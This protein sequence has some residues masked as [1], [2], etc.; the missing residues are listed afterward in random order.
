MFGVS[1]FYYICLINITINRFYKPKFLPNSSNMKKLF[2]FTLMVVTF[3]NFQAQN[4]NIGFKAGA[5]YA[6]LTNYE[7]GYSSRFAYHFGLVAELTLTDNFSIQPEILF[8]KL[9]TQFKDGENQATI[10][11]NYLSVPLMFKYHFSDKF[12]GEIGPYLG[13]MLTAHKTGKIE[14]E[15]IDE[16][17]ILG[18][19]QTDFGYAIGLSYSITNNVVG[20]VR[21]NLG[22][23]NVIKNSEDKINN[24]VFQL[25][26]GYN[27]F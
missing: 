8:S 23:K 4:D 6:N 24:S 1:Y 20:S 9:G 10:S 25:S 3:T 27:L 11:E 18:Y 2:L 22:T 15:T 12:S 17:I 16:D 19:N 14:G 5:N 26:L 7:D 21:Y 13:L